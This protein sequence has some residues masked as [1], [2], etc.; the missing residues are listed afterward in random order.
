MK[1]IKGFRGKTPSFGK[2]VF[3]AD[4][5]SIIGDVNIGTDSAI[6]YGCTVRGDINYIRIGERTNIQDNSVIHVDHYNHDIGKAGHPT[7]IGD[8][9]TVGHMVML[10]GCIVGNACLIGM[11]STL[12]DGCEIGAESIVGAG[13]LVTKN[14]KFP[15]RSLIMGRPA[16]VVRTLK[17]E[18]VAELYKGA[19]RYV[20]WKDEY[21]AEE[22]EA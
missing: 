14:K 22:N 19:K 11:N 6:W 3:I 17:E 15:P 9:V 8:D 10:H 16:K 2:R 4:N 18:E 12:L 13:S 21:L 5:V 20:T 1:L 7:F